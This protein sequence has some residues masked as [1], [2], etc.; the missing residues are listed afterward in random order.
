M[1]ISLLSWI[2]DRDL[3][4]ASRS[5]TVHIQWLCLCELFMNQTVMQHAQNNK[6]SEHALL[7]LHVSLNL[8]LA[9]DKGGKEEEKRVEKP[10]KYNFRS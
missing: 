9:D 2:R 1:C 10:L 4:A 3:N 5:S 6:C 8:A 7:L